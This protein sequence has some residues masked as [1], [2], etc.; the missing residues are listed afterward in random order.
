M[1]SSSIKHGGHCQFLY[2]ESG[3]AE[4]HDIDECVFIPGCGSHELARDQVDTNGFEHSSGNVWY[5]KQYWYALS[6]R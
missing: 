5:F 1:A 6:G 4:R 2:L 3:Q